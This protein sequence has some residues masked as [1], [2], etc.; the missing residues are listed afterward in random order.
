M[1]EQS[2]KHGRSVLLIAES[3][4]CCSN[5]NKKLKFHDVRILLK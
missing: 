5:V 4:F 1:K 3:V 2:L